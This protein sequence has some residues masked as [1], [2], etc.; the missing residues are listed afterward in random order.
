M[1][2]RTCISILGAA[3]ILGLG[4]SPSVAGI[5]SLSGAFTE[6]SPPPSVEEGNLE[7][8]TEYFVFPEQINFE[9]PSILSVDI[10]SPGSYVGKGALSPGTIPLGTAVDSYFFHM[11]PPGTNNTQ[12]LLGSVTFS[13]DILGIIVVAGNLDGSDL[14]VPYPGTLYPTGNAVIDRGSLDSSADQDSME[15]LSDLRTIN[16]RLYVGSE[17]VEQFRVITAIPEPTTGFLVAFGLIGLAING[18][19]RKA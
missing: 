10:T 7:S 8:G 13:T 17:N 15:L 5:I 9:L 12:I 19:R 2:Q 14:V 4:V 16:V 18:R 11:D 1:F 3:A 6:I